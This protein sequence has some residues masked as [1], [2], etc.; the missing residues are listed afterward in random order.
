[1]P[2]SQQSNDKTI[3]QSSSHPFRGDGGGGD[4]EDWTEDDDCLVE[5][6]E[7][8]AAWLEARGTEI[9]H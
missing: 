3:L 9:V 2:L 1:M 8:Y 4:D 6:A 7:M 5:A